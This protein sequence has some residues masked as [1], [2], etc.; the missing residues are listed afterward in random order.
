MLS[1]NPLIVVGVFFLIIFF[2]ALIVGLL[3][4]R[5]RAVTD[6]ASRKAP[7]WVESVTSPMPLEGERIASPISEAIEGMVQARMLDDPALEGQK[8]DFGT[9]DDGTLEIWIDDERYLDV[10][11]IPDENIRTI[12]QEAVKTYNEGSA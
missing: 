6:A 2:V 1:S 3:V 11:A 12:I 9:A 10:D 4:Q 7:D 8:I 5:R